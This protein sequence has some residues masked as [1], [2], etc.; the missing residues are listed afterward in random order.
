MVFHGVITRFC[1]GSFELHPAGRPE[2]DV[3][4]TAANLDMQNNPA[5]WTSQ[6]MCSLANGEL[7]DP[8][9]SISSHGR[10][11]QD[12]VHT[13]HKIKHKSNHVSVKYDLAFETTDRSCVYISIYV[14]IYISI[15][16]LIGYILI[17]LILQWEINI[18]HTLYKDKHW[19]SEINNASGKDK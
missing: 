7:I 15:P 8:L 17:A 6:G 13:N 10:I 3:V 11:V 14:S 19:A 5:A 4:W 2:G 1:R 18:Y 9:N 16:P 12:T